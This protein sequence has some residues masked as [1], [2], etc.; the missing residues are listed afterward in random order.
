[1]VNCCDLVGLSV[2]VHE[3]KTI[4]DDNDPT[5]I[6]AHKKVFDLLIIEV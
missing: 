4:S 1:M 2:R 6:K 5:K 3:K